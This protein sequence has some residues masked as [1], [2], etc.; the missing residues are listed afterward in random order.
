MTKVTLEAVKVN[1]PVLAGRAAELGAGAGA[2]PKLASRFLALPASQM[3]VSRQWFVLA[4]V[5]RLRGMDPQTCTRPSTDRLQVSDG[6]HLV[7][8]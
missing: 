3:P 4:I 1:T 5:F 8:A 6:M 7:F 2:G